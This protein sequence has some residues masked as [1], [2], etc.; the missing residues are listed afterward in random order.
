[1]KNAKLKTSVI[2]YSIVSIFLIV[3]AYLYFHTK[4][5]AE[6][7]V[8]DRSNFENGIIN[9]GPD[10]K[11]TLPKNPETL[12]PLIRDTEGQ[13]QEK[14]SDEKD[15]LEH[16][17]VESFNRGD[18]RGAVELFTELSKKE[19]RAFI[20]LGLSYYSLGNYEKA[21]DSLEEGLR[22]GE[23]F[24]ARKL[25]A[26]IYYKKNDIDKSLYN[27][28]K[29]LSR[30]DDSELSALYKKLSKEKM[31]QGNFI[32][33]GTLHFSLFYDGYEHRELGRKVLNILEDAYSTI[34]RAMNYFPSESVTV[35]LY[36]EKNFYDITMKPEWTGG[37]Y[38]GKIRVPIKGAEGKEEMLR[39]VLFHEYTHALV[40]SIT[41]RCPLW[42]NEGLA[43]Y[44]SGGHASRIGQ[45]L[46]LRSLEKS[47]S[48]LQKDKVIVAYRESYSAVA[49][50]IDRY[51]LFRVKELL[52]SFSEGKDINQAFKDVFYISYDEFISEWGK[53]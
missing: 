27:A 53:G 51:G 22:Y 49:Y 36:A 28:E 12:L 52:F 33:E 47:F 16:R 17:A 6:T 44:F 18:Y 26:F 29:G 8:T 9:S 2:G 45:V 13:T 19:P 21:L 31:A 4:R 39:K 24:I 7:Q 43:E 23:E 25:L 46:P 48:G 34:G 41:A 5:S 1:M 30:Q 20:E 42:I 32:K 38:D 40:R 14:S 50:L 35:I 11:L 37:L 10:I 15:G 3:T